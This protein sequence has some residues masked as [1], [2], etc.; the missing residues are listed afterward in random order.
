[1]MTKNTYE[2][3]IPINF[4]MFNVRDKTE[5]IYMFVLLTSG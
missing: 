2:I 5:Q 3:H 1:M 4:K